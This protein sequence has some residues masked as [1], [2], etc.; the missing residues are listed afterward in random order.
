MMAEEKK[1]LVAQLDDIP[2]ISCPCG[3]TRRA[4]TE[5]A[6][7]RASLHLLDVQKDAQLHYH[8][9][10]TEIYFILEGEGYLEIDGEQV[11]VKPMTGILIKPGCRHRAVGKLRV[12]ITAIPAFDP[13]DE[14]FD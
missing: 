14:W 12:A 11:P 3:F 6:D 4:F 13:E 9:R 5:D 2:T 10:I 1:F 7:Q 8:K